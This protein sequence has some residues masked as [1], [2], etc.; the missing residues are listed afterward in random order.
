MHVLRMASK[1]VINQAVFAFVKVGAL[2]QFAY[3]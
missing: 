1:L 2:P 3:W